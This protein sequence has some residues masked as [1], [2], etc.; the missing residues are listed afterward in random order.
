MATSG[1]Y[2]FTLTEEDIIYSALRKVGMIDPEGQTASATLIG[3]SAQT[4]N[5]MIKAWQAD[6][7]Q[8]WVRKV[9]TIF[10]TASQAKYQLGSDYGAGGAH[11]SLSHVYTTSGAASSGASTITV[12]SA[13]G[14]SN[15]DNI[16][17]YQDDGT[18]HWTTLNGA[19]SG[20]TLTLTN[21][22]TDD[23]ASGNVVYTYTNKLAKPLRVYDGFMRNTSN[24]DTPV[25][26]ISKEEYNRFGYKAAP[27]TTTQVMWEQETG[28]MN[29]YLYP[30]PTDPRLR[31][32]LELHYPFQDFDVTTNN[33]DFPSE[34][35]QALIWGLALELSFEAGLEEKRIQLIGQTAK[36]WR[37]L[38]LGASQ[39]NSVYFQPDFNWR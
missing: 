5:A 10:L 15:G 28:N 14:M 13:T 3:N 24:Y 30:V 7:L 2:N 25:R 23:V 8:I 18:F 12:A 27:G 1:S 4:L 21:A 26:I 9:A 37:D 29:V 20:T 39:E 19:P 38:A 16:G 35:F 22:L 11:A 31:L 32:Y 36:Y 17:I 6:G 33:A 34:W